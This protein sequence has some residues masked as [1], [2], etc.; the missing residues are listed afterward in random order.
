MGEADALVAAV[1]AGLRSPLPIAQTIA[2]LGIDLP[3]IMTRATLAD[4]LSEAIKLTA[5][6]L[7]PY[8][9]PA[10]R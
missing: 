1:V 5:G 4:A 3:T 10:P 9:A 7:V 8:D 6:S 2:Q